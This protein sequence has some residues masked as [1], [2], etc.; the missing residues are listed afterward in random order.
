M[1]SFSRI[2][3]WAVLSIVVVYLA[4]AAFRPTPSHEGFDW[5]AFGR[6]PVQVGGRVKP[7]DTLARNSLFAIDHKTEFDEQV[8]A[9]DPKD[10]NAKVTIRQ[11]AT[12]W[13][14][15]VLLGEESGRQLEVFR[16]VNS[17]VLSSLKLK[18]RAGLRYALN[19]IPHEVS[20]FGTYQSDEVAALYQWARRVDLNQQANAENRRAKNTDGYVD[21]TV[22][23]G[24]ARD[25]TRKISL[26]QYLQGTLLLPATGDKFAS[27]EDMQDWLT[28]TMYTLKRLPTRPT[29]GTP[30]LIPRDSTSRDWGSLTDALL[31]AISAKV[32]PGQSNQ[33]DTAA[34]RA[35]KITPQE[36]VER[37][38]AESPDATWLASWWKM[39]Q[40]FRANDAEAFNEEVSKY[41][42]ALEDAGVSIDTRLSVEMF[43]NRFQPFYKGIV[44]SGLALFLIGASWFGWRQPLLRAALGIIILSVVIQTLGLGARMYLENRPFVFVT[45]LYSSAVFI[46]WIAVISGL[47]LEWIY[48][49][50]IGLT[51]ACIVSFLSLIVAHNLDIAG[52][53]SDN[54]AVLQAVLDTN[55]WLATH[56]TTVTIGYCATYLAGCLGAT[57]IVLGIFTPALDRERAKIYTRQIYGVTCAALTLSFIGTVLG[58][59]WADQS[60]GRFWGWDPKENGALIIVL[61][62]ALILHARWGGIVRQKGLAILAIF[63]NI[64]TTWSWFGTNML[65][66]GLHAYGK[67]DRAFFWMM[68][69]M[70]CNLAIMA[71]GAFWP[72]KSWNSYDAM[73]QNPPKRRGG[74]RIKNASPA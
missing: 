27:P 57:Y 71:L 44:L 29:Q 32:R 14:A 62:N 15:D 18:E 26:Y 42:A 23:D 4:S 56:V 60:W 47:V 36:F 72:E 11:P 19:E 53:G 69:F 58:G 65:G 63:G 6:L 54:L 67:M 13:L 35:G 20:K 39:Q 24:Q 25:L 16:I 5:D 74:K 55:F 7:L 73:T 50:S 37:A 38:I 40:A 33:E 8:S 48:R 31:S 3:P 41:P 66:V 2:F 1:K 34:L 10:P 59:I 68:V 70:L 30:R 61:W 45:N 64:V 9:E 51:V 17:D 21:I 52:Q 43:M 28:G 46:G 12:R 49:D 22:A